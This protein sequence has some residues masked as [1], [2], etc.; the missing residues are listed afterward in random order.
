[1]KAILLHTALAAASIAHAQV[2]VQGGIRFTG[3]EEGTARIIGLAPPTT[4]PAVIPVSVVASGTVHWANATLSGNILQLALTPS[5]E[6]FG[7]GF[8]LRF[9][10]PVDNDGPMLLSLSGDTPVPLVNTAGEA[11]HWRTLRRGAAAEV[12]YVNGSWLLL[13]PAT[14]T[15]PPGSIPT[16]GPVCMDVGSIP[17]L[18]FY[19]AIDHCA[20]RGGKLC[21]WDEYAVGCAIREEQLAGLF[22][23]W[24][25]ID[26]TSNHTHTANQ[27]GRFTCQSQRSANVIPLMTGDTRCCYRIR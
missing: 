5:G 11:L 18:L 8:I 9:S 12:M 21:S 13:N 15:C 25:W 16:A 19:Q 1:M 23:E 27:A 4:G 17:G 24:E 10:S 26:D 6:E 7:N 22:N 20:S 14:T 3:N 2:Y